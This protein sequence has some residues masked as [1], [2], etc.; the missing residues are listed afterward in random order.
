MT[1]EDLKAMTIDERRAIYAEAQRAPSQP[2]RTSALR[3]QAWKRS[4]SGRACERP[5]STCP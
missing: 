2:F 1:P 3:F 5:G 4:V